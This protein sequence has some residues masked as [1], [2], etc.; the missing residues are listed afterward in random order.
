MLADMVKNGVLQFSF[1]Y[2]IVEKKF[3]KLV[4]SLD[5]SLINGDEDLGFGDLL[6]TCLLEL[7]EYDL[8]AQY[9]TFAIN[10]RVGQVSEDEKD[11][12]ELCLE[13]NKVVFERL[14]VSKQPGLIA[15]VSEYMMDQGLRA[16]IA[17]ETHQDKS[18]KDQKAIDAQIE[19][20]FKAR[21]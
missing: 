9:Y 11:I 6:A 8:E 17:Y 5:D 21:Q 12:Y 10:P 15:K 2:K 7:D 13:T 14:L 1:A 4:K 16:V 18:L 20:E 19:S 3:A